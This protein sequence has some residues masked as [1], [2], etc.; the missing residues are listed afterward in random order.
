MVEQPVAV[1]EPVAVEDVPE[2]EAEESL[3]GD[4][5]EPTGEAEP[6][7]EIEEVTAAASG[8]DWSRPDEDS[9]P[10]ADPE[11]EIEYDEYV[12]PTA[13]AVDT[14]ASST[15]DEQVPEAVVES[16]DDDVGDVEVPAASV[17]VDQSPE[18]DVHQ[19]PL[20]DDVTAEPIS[21]EPQREDPQP[22]GPQPGE[23]T[24]EA[25][26]DEAVHSNGHGVRALPQGAGVPD[27]RR[28]LFGRGRDKKAPAHDHA[29]GDP[30]TIG[31]LTR[32]VCDI[33]GHV[34]FSG[35]DVYQGW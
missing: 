19:S 23:L 1:E 28:S 17:Q 7:Y 16:T 2:V 34:T 18:Q 10:I 11:P 5:V 26:T 31:G 27:R 25:P 22:Q 21:A 24:S 14:F 32:Q 9:S 12:L 35:E 15:P 29:Y 4:S 30:K 8:A 33:C 13:G 20:T 3:R 6:E